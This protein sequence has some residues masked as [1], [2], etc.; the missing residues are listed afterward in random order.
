MRRL[1]VLLLALGFTIAAPASTF[2]FV[3]NAVAVTAA[4]QTI[5]VGTAARPMSS[6]VVDNTATGN[7][8]VYARLFRTGEAITPAAA[9]D[10]G[11]YAIASGGILNRSSEQNQPGYVA[12]SLVCAGGDTATAKVWATAR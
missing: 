3:D 11:G 10:S 8:V 2:D 4:A 6:I 7:D 1:F 5:T 12:V 9:T